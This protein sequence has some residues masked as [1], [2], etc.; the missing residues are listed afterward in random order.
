MVRLSMKDLHA[1]V[2]GA[3]KWSLRPEFVLPLLLLCADAAFIGIHLLHNYYGRPADPIYSLGRER[4]Y[5]EVY[6][7]LKLFWLVVLFGMLA[8]TRRQLVHVGWMAL[9]AGI[10]IDDSFALHE[11]Y[12]LQAAEMLGLQPALGL[13]A[14]DLG[15]L[16]FLAAAGAALLTA[17]GLTYLTAN[18]AERQFSKRLVRLIALLV[19]FGIVVDAV[20]SIARGT[21]AST[22]LGVLEDGG[23]MVMVSLILGVVFSQTLVWTAAARAESD[24]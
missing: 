11:Q 23:E 13:R 5:A 18:A 21:W 1:V 3:P 19:F 7:Y 20:H 8:V 17:L 10:L 16:I 12:G 9:L 24:A 6:Q 22:P 15:E 14:R 4:G 2:D